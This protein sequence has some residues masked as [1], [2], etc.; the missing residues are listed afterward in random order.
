MTPRIERRREARWRPED[1]AVGRVRIRA[2]TEAALIDCSS[3]GVLISTSMR[4]LP[5]RRC[6]LAWPHAPGTP[7]AGGAIVRS[8]VG[9]LDAQ[10]GVHYHAAVQFDTPAPFLRV[11]GAQ[12][13]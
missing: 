3:T 9:R 12:G 1:V 2:G 5:G 6:V 4:L 13:G 10:T 8:S 7:S 11:V